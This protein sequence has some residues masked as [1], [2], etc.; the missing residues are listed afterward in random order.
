MQWRR[1]LQLRQLAVKVA[2]TTSTKRVP[3]QTVRV[4][5]VAG[6][7]IRLNQKQRTVKLVKPARHV[8]RLPCPAVLPLTVFYLLHPH[9]RWS[10]QH[11][12][13]ALTQRSGKNHRF[14]ELQAQTGSVLGL[15]DRYLLGIQRSD[16]RDLNSRSAHGSGDF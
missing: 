1:T 9:R 12:L 10:Q 7:Q 5:K 2:Q 4:T 8:I 15:S 11:N 13:P 14:P 3:K 16:Y 6:K